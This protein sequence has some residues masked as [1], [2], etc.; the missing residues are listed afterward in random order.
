MTGAGRALQPSNWHTRSRSRSFRHGVVDEHPLVITISHAQI[1]GGVPPIHNDPF[2]RLF[3][4]QAPVERFTLV[5][6]DK[7]IKL[8]SVNILEA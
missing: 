1:A 6:R 3:I 7:N 5:T 4:A 8:Y 2:D